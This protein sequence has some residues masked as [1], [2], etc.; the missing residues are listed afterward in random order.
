MGWHVR[1]PSLAKA[2]PA[3]GEERL[4]HGHASRVKVPR[5]R[6]GRLPL[7]SFRHLSPE[8]HQD[9]PELARTHL[10]QKRQGDGEGVEAGDKISEHTPPTINLLKT[11]TRQQL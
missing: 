3:E 4:Q 8:V 6:R 2:R 7:L 11:R 1:P 9:G 10:Q 5:V